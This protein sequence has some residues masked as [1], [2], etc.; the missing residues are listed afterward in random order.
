V[1]VAGIYG[2]GAFVSN[3][4]GA[5]FRALGNLRSSDQ[6]VVDFSDPNRATMLSV[7]H[8]TLDLRRSTDGGRTWVDIAAGIPAVAGF[9][10]GAVMV[11][12][13]TYLLGTYRG[14]A[15]GI[16]R[17]T[18]AGATWTQVATGSVAGA[19]LVRADGSIWWV[20]EGGR[21]VARSTDGGVTWEQAV[22]GGILAPTAPTIIELPG[23]RLA[24][25]S[26][27]VVVSADDGRTW[28][29]VGGSLPFLPV[30]MTY[31]SFRKSFFVWRFDCSDTPDIPIPVGETSIM[32]LVVEDLP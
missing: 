10:L 30:G 20:L 22:R 17:T 31:S 8:E 28:R 26:R 4:S 27:T 7:T 13:T 6:L 24:S 29:A 15:T 19:P 25:F 2:Q 23:G 3:D 1:Y 14:T 9:S 32:Q 16:F 18:D 12:P 11:N 21:G 5:T